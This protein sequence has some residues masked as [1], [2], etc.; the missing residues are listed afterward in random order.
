MKFT[1]H[2][3][4]IN[5][6]YDCYMLYGK[7]TEPNQRRLDLHVKELE[8]YVGQIIK[9]Y[10]YERDKKCI[11]QNTDDL[12]AVI[13]HFK[14]GVQSDSEQK[15]FI[16]LIIFLIILVLYIQQITGDL[17]AAILHFEACVQSVREQKPFICFII[18]LIIFVFIYRVLMAIKNSHHLFILG[19]RGNRVPSD[20]G[21]V[22]L[23]VQISKST[24]QRQPHQLI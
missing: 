20:V 4:V 5:R 3:I 13:L 14:T 15:P 16:C 7:S 11:E 6:I 23:G 2:I 18:F 24:A 19:E 1:S 17:N 12:N 21:Y 10:G 8:L 22:C 9:G